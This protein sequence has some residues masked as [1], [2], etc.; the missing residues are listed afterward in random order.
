MTHPRPRFRPLEAI[1][2]GILAGVLVVGGIAWASVLLVALG[3]TL[4]FVM[5]SPEL[6]LMMAVFVVIVLVA[7]AAV[8]ASTG[9]RHA[10]GLR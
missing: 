4:G 1:E 7:K 8:V 9:H 10:S 3:F 5:S 2:A 6:V